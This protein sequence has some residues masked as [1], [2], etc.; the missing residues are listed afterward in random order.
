[1]SLNGMDDKFK[2]T[3]AAL[4]ATMRESKG[5]SHEVRPGK[6]NLNNLVK[7]IKTGKLKLPMLKTSGD[8]II[9]ALDLCAQH[10]PKLAVP[11]THLYM[12]VNNVGSLPRPDSSNVE[13]LRRKVSAQRRRMREKFQRDIIS[14]KGENAVRATVDDNDVLLNVAV[15]QTKK[16]FSA[17]QAQKEVDAIMDVKNIKPNEQNHDLLKWY[18]DAGPV[19]DR[20]LKQ[21]PAL[22]SGEK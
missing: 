21:M 20:A 16:V 22:T 12:L 17:I 7:D 2:G 10:Y 8:K 4:D 1:M 5:P 13:H 19:L 11:Y 14:I 6:N 3:L 15:N 18:K 9:H